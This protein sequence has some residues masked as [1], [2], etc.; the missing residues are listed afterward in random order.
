MIFY[1]YQSL[2]NDFIL[3][4]WLETPPLFDIQSPDWRAFVI[5]SCK[6][7]TGIG[8]DGI[9]VITKGTT[10][11]ENVAIFNA[12]GSDG[13]L[14]LNGARAAALHLKIYHNYPDQFT[15]TMG[16]SKIETTIENSPRR[17][18]IT[19]YLPLGEVRGNKTIEVADNI[20]SGEVVDVGNPHFI[21]FEKQNLR[22][23]EKHGAAIEQ[24]EAFPNKT[25][26]EFIWP[27]KEVDNKYHVLVYERGC[28]ITLG[29]SSGA[30][31]I[32]TL[33]HKKEKLPL[34]EAIKIIMPGGIVTCSVKE[35]L[36][37][38][39]G[40]ATMVFEGEI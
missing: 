38:L 40:E 13:E 20:L 14:C 5:N 29:C 31:A 6:R 21:I 4:D 37:S 39:Q 17:N 2:G 9:L 36:V 15:L 32:T 8:A 16:E 1:K 30:A 11:H 3:L 35:D 34:G 23:L 25:N 28:G 18:L 19:Q 22:W 24:H 26:V 7:H 27:D 12:D 10:L 33:L